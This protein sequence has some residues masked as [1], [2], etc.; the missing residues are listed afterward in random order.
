MSNNVSKIFK[1]NLIKELSNLS[2]SIALLHDSIK[3][4]EF[5]ELSETEKEYLGFINTF[6]N[7]LI[8]NYI[9]EKIES[10]TLSEKLALKKAN[11]KIQELEKAS[12]S[13][14]TL[15]QI[16]GYI[17]KEN[18]ELS[19]HLIQ[20]G[21]KCGLKITLHA[22]ALNIELSFYPIRKK[23]LF[24]DY[25]NSIEDIEKSEND[26]KM[27]KNNYISNFDIVNIKDRSFYLTPSNKNIEK[28]QEIMQEY[29]KDITIDS[30]EIKEQG[31]NQKSLSDMNFLI[32]TN[33]FFLGDR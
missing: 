11:E 12:G 30:I 8:Q 16:S 32:N 33:S 2:G 21:I 17:K 15:S 31:E 18:D 5:K 13:E 19:K 27:L 4:K 14:L 24:S 20:Y 3:D 1:S 29:N 6:S 25:N 26:R 28:I 22:Y 7:S 23:E 9:P 10:K